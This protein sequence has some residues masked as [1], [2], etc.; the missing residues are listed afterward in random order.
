MPAGVTDRLWEVSDIAGECWRLGSVIVFVVKPSDLGWSIFKDGQ[1][2]GAF[3]SRRKTLEALS[4]M[5]RELKA[6]G[7]RSLIKFE[8]RVTKSN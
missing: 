1:F 7:E 2:V 8:P 3:P 4:N 5:R 6:K